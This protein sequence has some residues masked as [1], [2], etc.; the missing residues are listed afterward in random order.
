M[1]R[2]FM[3]Q[4][5]LGCAWV[6]VLL[7]MRPAIFLDGHPESEWQFHTVPDVNLFGLKVILNTA[8]D[9][10]LFFFPQR[11]LRAYLKHVASGTILHFF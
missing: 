10:P 1:K 9:N 8:N 6:L 11:K 7:N 5:D 3:A 2:Y 4:A